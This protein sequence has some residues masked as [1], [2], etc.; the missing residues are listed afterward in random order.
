M[1]EIDH[2]KATAQSYIDAI[3]RHDVAAILG[4][5]DEDVRIYTMSSTMLP[6][7]LDKKGLSDFM[8][9]M[10]RSFP[11]GIE[12]TVHNMVGEANCV[13]L[14]AESQGIHISGRA[15]NNRYHFLFRFRDRR[16]VELK[17]YC[18]TQHVSDILADEIAHR[19]RRS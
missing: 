17:E 19:T 9:L 5:M 13:A 2:N 14:E 18:D 6:G 15:F 10:R 4:L 12:M 7:H 11:E 1:G 16:I 8:Q 3:T